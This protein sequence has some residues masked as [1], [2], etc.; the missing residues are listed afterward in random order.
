MF[1]ANFLVL[2]GVGQVPYRATSKNSHLGLE[3]SG[4]LVDITGGTF[5]QTFTPSATL[6]SGWFVYLRNSGTGDITLNPYSTELIDGLTSYVMYPGECRLI[7]C[8]GSAFTSVVISPFTKTF[9][10]TGTFTTP[11]GY[12]QFNGLL[13]GGGGSGGKGGAGYSTGG[14]GGGSC[15]PFM[16]TSS[17][18]GLSQTVTIAAGGVAVSANGNG[19]AG[20]DS[21]IGSL[22][23]AYGGGGGGGAAAASYG[24]GTGAGIYAAG[25]AGSTVATNVLGGSPYS[26][27]ETT[28]T[29][30]QAINQTYGG[31][32]SISGRGGSSV[33]GGGGGKSEEVSS[34]YGNSLYGGGGGGGITSG[35]SLNARG[36]SV[37]GGSGGAAGV[38]VNGTDGTQP[39]GG[40]GATHTGTNSGAG[41]AGQCTIW[42]V[43]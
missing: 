2:P 28:G 4:Y 31:G 41:G 26:W 35:N 7:Q 27:V 14:G 19:N 30:I 17:A 22:V 11:P 18:I 25:A 1:P 42:G 36:T 12:R 29:P 34:T 21:T 13:W 43:A 33:Y 20:G 5:T 23:T 16:L 15:V 39:S 3:D 10:V 32:G 38:A 40:G 37:F 9:L 24:G 6:G 8:T